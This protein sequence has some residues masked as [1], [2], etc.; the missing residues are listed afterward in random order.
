MLQMN[1]QQIIYQLERLLDKLNDCKI[2]GP[3]SYSP[4]F[5]EAERQALDHAIKFMSDEKNDASNIY[6]I[7]DDYNKKL[8]SEIQ[9][10]CDHTWGEEH[11]TWSCGGY[12][13]CTKCGKTEDFYERD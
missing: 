11:W 12:R 9:A 2:K 6:K 4:Y 1:K 7:K 10:H 8:Q 13:K 3:K 5:T